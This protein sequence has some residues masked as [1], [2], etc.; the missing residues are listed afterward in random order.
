MKYPYNNPNLRFKDLISALFTSTEKAEQQVISFFSRLTGK[1][2]ILI[3][4]SC[5]TALYLSYLTLERK[6]EVLT[7]PLTCK[8]AIDPIV[9]SEN[10]P[11]YV[12]VNQGTLNMAS[13]DIEHR[14][15][16]KTVAIQTIHLGGVSCDM[17]PIQAIARKNNLPLIEDCAQSL[18]ATYDGK[19]S[20]S[21]GDI[22]CF[23]LIKNAYG[24]GGGIFATN[25]KE[26]YLKA[27]EKNQSFFKPQ[28]KIISF[29]IIRNLI[30]TKQNNFFWHFPFRLLLKLKN[31]RQSYRSVVAQCYRI[32]S[33]EIKVA[34]RQLSR[35]NNLQIIRNRIGK[36]YFHLLNETSLMANNNYLPK[37]SS[38]TKFFVF[39]P[40]INT[41]V[42]LDLLNK[43]GIEA[44]HLEDKTG[45]PY[46]TQLIEKLKAKE[47][48]L[49]NYLLI[50]DHLISLPMN[51]KMSRNDIE[52]IISNLT[53]DKT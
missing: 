39:H 19:P 7:S 12:D 22:A 50:H 8:V 14:I 24:I 38:F 5:R 29:R 25:N 46:Q 31:Q 32:T 37:E 41:L 33:I 49:E 16:Q 2:Y 11:V 48:G 42:D 20:G 53:S 4:N 52:I 30:A 35:F 28:R 21:F 17:T 13:E 40:Q 26:Y 3:T 15:T 51:T 1:K 43:K 47:E 9:E 45:S 23:S 44:K 6:G 18:G 10:E 34:A 36:V 27:V